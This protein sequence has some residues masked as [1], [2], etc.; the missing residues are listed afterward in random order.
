MRAYT[1]A[2]PRPAATFYDPGDF[3]YIFKSNVDGHVVFNQNI[4]HALLLVIAVDACYFFRQ[5]TLYDECL[6]ILKVDDVDGHVASYHNIMYI[7]DIITAV[8]LY[9]RLLL[10]WRNILVKVAVFRNNSRENG[11]A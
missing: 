8:E 6:F 1:H 5:P 10:R 9:I 2:V 4:I 11:N 3:S 7:R